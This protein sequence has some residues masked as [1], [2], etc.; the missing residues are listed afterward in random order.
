MDASVAEKKSYTRDEVAAHSAD[1]D[2]WVI[3]SNKVYDVSKYM[4]V[5]PGGK[6]IL[7]ANA[8]GQ[9]ATEAYEEAD[10]TKRAR[11]MVTKYYVGDLIAE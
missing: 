3:I 4:G 11:E 7:L 10:H 2:C 9:D 6:D 8:N 1:G 5:H